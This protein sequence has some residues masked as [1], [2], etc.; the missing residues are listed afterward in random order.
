[1]LR[2]LH[3]D[4]TLL[5]VVNGTGVLAVDHLKLLVGVVGQVV[6]SSE[7]TSAITLSKTG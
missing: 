2:S 3:T 1:M 5:E 6:A 7:Y 4:K